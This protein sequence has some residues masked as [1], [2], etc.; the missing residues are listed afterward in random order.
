MEKKVKKNKFKNFMKRFWFIVWKDD[1]IRGWIISLIFIF[2]LI[3]LIFFPTL[4]L[5]TG[6]KMPLVIV[7][8]CSMYHQGDPFSNFNAWWDGH[9]LKYFVMKIS[10][11]VWQ[12][13]P[14]KNGFNKGDVIF[15]TG[16]KP[17]KVKIGDVII[18]RSGV[19]SSPVIHRVMKITKT[20]STYIFSTE[21]DNNNGQLI[22]S[23]NP[24][25]KINEVSIYPDQ[26]IGQARAVIIPYI[27]WAKLIFFEHLKDPSERGF[28]TQTPSQ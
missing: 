20:N 17:D 11:N 13:F 4:S 10:K 14:L 12:T 28:C 23:N 3:K 24:D 7:E 6:T 27:G 21:G 15:V 8:S 26:L 18:F 2:I 1:S 9:D 16:V 25:T 22:P 5:V 19:G